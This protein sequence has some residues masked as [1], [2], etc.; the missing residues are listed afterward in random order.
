MRFKPAIRPLAFA[1][2]AFLGL[3]IIPQFA[4]ASG[5]IVVKVDEALVLRL[6]RPAKRIILGNPA[7]VDVAAQA[8]NLLVLTGKSFGNTNII[9]L[10]INNNEILN[11][12][13]TVQ[14]LSE[15]ALTLHRGSD[16]FNYTCRPYCQSQMV[17][18]D[19]KDYYE[20]I[21]KQIEN[22]FN[23]ITEVMSGHTK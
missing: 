20:N 11:K 12:K 1:C 5:Q 17:V 9:A 13:L 14:L 18:G 23:L 3:F 21:A 19:Q 2:L 16:R 7:I 8:N 10:D 6:D 22:K 15:T 4:R